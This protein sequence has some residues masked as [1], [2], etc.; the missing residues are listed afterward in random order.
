[1]KLSNR[2]IAALH[3]SLSILNGQELTG[4]EIDGKPV[5]KPL[6]FKIAY[7]QSRTLAHLR[8]A[9]DAIEAA[10]LAIVR[11]YSGGAAGLEQTNPAFIEC[12]TEVTALLDEVVEVEVHQQPL[13]EFENLGLAPAMLADL[14]PLII[15]E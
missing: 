11:K 5:T 15:P 7:A 4:K 6:P 9:V 14:F 1:M 8:P 2:A 12:Q 3:R 13:K 10:R